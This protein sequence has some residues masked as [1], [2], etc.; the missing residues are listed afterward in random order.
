MYV[1][2]QQTIGSGNSS[3]HQCV[4]CTTRV[5]KTLLVMG[6][7]SF[8]VSHVLH[9]GLFTVLQV[10]KGSTPLAIHACIPYIMVRIYVVGFYWVD[11]MFRK[12]FE[13]SVSKVSGPV[14]SITVSWSGV[15][16]T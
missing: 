16:T 5:W 8:L 2:D 10:G 14:G 7:R 3:S 6:R 9:L 15:A 13:Y 1:V 4:V 11:E 12:T